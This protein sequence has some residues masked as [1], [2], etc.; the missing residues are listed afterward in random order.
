MSI[1]FIPA[2]CPNCGGELRVP[3]YR[4]NIKCMYCGYDIIMHETK[5]NSAQPS[6][7]NWLKLADAA[8]SSNPEEA[9]GYYTKVL[10][11]DPENWKAWY[12]KAKAAGSKTR[13]IGNISSLANPRINEVVNEI[14]KAIEFCPENEKDKLIDAAYRELFILA[15]AFDINSYAVYQESEDYNNAFFEYYERWK[16]IFSIFDYILLILTSSNPDYVVLAETGMNKCERLIELIPASE[17]NGFFGQELRKKYEYYLNKIKVVN[18]AY[19]LKIEN[20]T[21]KT[22]EKNSTSCFI[23]TATMGNYDNPYVI[24]LCEFRDKMLT[25][26]RFGRKFIAIYYRYSPF[27]AR[28]IKKSFS[29]RVLSR[30]LIVKPSYF[31][32]NLFIKQRQPAKSE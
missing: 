17:R 6:L 11:V 1:E 2:I 20:P 32:A 25:K 13:E 12:G 9:Y 30:Y 5:S 28:L 18:P 19:Q 14:R 3:E 31:L 8:E 26:T 16:L 10:E 29:L 24:T 27:M 4:K 21:T 22:Q 7:E 15:I 23:A